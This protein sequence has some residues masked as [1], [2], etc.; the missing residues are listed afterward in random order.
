MCLRAT[1]WIKYSKLSVEDVFQRF[2]RR[3][4]L[5][6]HRGAETE[7]R[8]RFQII[9]PQ[10]IHALDGRMRLKAGL[11]C[12]VSTVLLDNRPS[13][14]DVSS[15]RG[16]AVALPFPRTCGVQSRMQFSRTE[17]PNA[18]NVVKV[19]SLGTASSLDRPCRPPG[20]VFGEV[21]PS[22]RDDHRNARH[23]R[24]METSPR[25]EERADSSA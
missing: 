11:A 19:S 13:L 1:W 18:Q 9:S 15:S 14:R 25:S 20:V 23:R 6:G 17:A 22:F 5:P 21:R 24:N 10:C 12:D 2:A 8:Q 16:L 7:Q 3:L 4:L